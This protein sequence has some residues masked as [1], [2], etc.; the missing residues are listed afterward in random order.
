LLEAV[1]E[2]KGVLFRME[3]LRVGIIGCGIG[4]FHADS[5][6]QEPRARIVA[7]AGLD[8]ERC[9]RIA[10]KHNI[11]NLFHDYREL[12]ERSDIDAVSVGVPN[13]LHHE[14]ALAALQAGK[15]VLLE[16]PIARNAAE[17]EEIVRA[18]RDAGKVLGVFFS[19]RYKAEMNL[20]HRHI[21]SGGL[22]DIYYAKAFWMRRAGIPGLGSWFTRKELAGGGPLV[23][24]GVHVLDMALYLMGNPKVITVTGSTYAK[25]GPQGKGNWMDGR[26]TVQS[27]VYEVEDLATAFLRTADGAAIQ[28]ET[29]WAAH[30]GVTDEYG[31]ALMGDAGGAE[32]RVKD[33]AKTGTLRLFG[34]FAG[35]P[36]E[37]TPRYEPQPEHL[38]VITRFVDAVV[39]GVPMSPSGEEGLDRTRLLDAIYRSAELGREIC[40]DEAAEEAAAAD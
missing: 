14:V 28:L 9:L 22:G 20:L 37:V 39:D 21:L 11:L 35:T 40:L 34:D 10:R 19:K 2:G 29:S 31:I 38:Q 24:L 3:P 33:Y 5:W 30:S 18:A 23:D 36:T 13:Y 6:A 1:D 17:G 16:K 7:L 15:H 12:V 25:L 27:D 8:T 4:Q 26:F 32:I